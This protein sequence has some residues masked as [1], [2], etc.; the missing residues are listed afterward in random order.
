MH[1]YLS[2]DTQDMPSSFRHA[3]KVKRRKG[4]EKKN[5]TEGGSARQLK[6]KGLIMTGKA[7]D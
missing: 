5:L 6:Q 1:K 3:Q 7:S 4:K 2:D